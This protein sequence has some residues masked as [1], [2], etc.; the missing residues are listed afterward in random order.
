MDLIIE[1]LVIEEDRPEHIAKHKVTIDEVLEIVFG[2]YITARGKSDR[3]LLTGKTLNQR[4]ITVIIGQRVGLH[5]YGLVTARS[6]KKK[7]KLLYQNK[8]EKEDKK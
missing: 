8:F 5:R 2:D 6:A 1:E 4:L 7:E 3:I